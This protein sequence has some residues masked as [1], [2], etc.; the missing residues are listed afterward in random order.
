VVALGGYGHQYLDALLDRTSPDLAV[1]VGGVEPSP[2]KCGRLADLKRNRVPVLDS[3]E[4]FFGS[5]QADLTVISSPI[6]H[7]CAQVCLS[8]DHG[9]HVLCEKP[10]S[11]TVQDGLSMALAGRRAGRSVSIGY[12]W[13]F[14]DE[15][16]R[17]KSDIMS[18]IFGIP[19]RLASIVLWPRNEDYY[20]RNGWAGALRDD[21]GRWVLDSP[22]AN[23]TAHYLH[24]MLYCLGDTWN[25]SATPARIAGEL[26]RA[27][28]ISNYDTAALRCWTK[29]G[30]EVLFYASHATS[31][32]I[33]PLFRYEFEHATVLFEGDAGQVVA[34]FPGGREIRYGTPFN[35]V[36]IKLAGAIESAGTGAQTACPVEAAIPHVLCVNGLQEAVEDIID[37]PA[38]LVTVEGSPGALRRHV[39]GLEA[40]LTQCYQIGALP[41]ETD[42]PWA[43]AGRIVDLTGYNHFPRDRAQRHRVGPDSAQSAANAAVD[44]P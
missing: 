9:S 38:D 12:Q 11:A 22:V 30:V 1:I 37:F 33:G 41:A 4:D 25:T 29:S 18:G 10:L 17:L 6:Q 42:A 39:T 26:Y 23:A 28:P 14:S 35:G 5:H 13:S 16:Q 43:V 36:D 32:S 15:I 20:A 24:N 44:L 34:R 8:L 21:A 2:G 19:K 7:H 40:T 27:H 31:R 3:L